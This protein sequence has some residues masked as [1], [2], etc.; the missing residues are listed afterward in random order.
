MKIVSKTSI[1]FQ[2]E[3]GHELRVE[4]SNRG[5]PFRK[6]I[7]LSLELPEERYGA[8]LFLEDCEARKLRDLLNNLYPTIN[9]P[10]QQI[11]GLAR[12]ARPAHYATVL[13]KIEKIAV[14]ANTAVLNESA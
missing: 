10:L 14:M 2:A 8:H 4:H 3:D 9:V 7:E 11:A 1:T 12:D 5:E 13:D 6:G